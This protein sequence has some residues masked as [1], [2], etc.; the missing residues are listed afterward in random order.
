MEIWQRMWLQGSYNDGGD[1]EDDDD[2]DDC[3]S[4][5]VFDSSSM[6]CWINSND[7]YDDYDDNDNNNNNNN[8]WQ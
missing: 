6:L 2:D 7:D 4:A 8:N 5:G 3:M 1:D